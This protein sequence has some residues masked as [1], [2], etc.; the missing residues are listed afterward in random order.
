MYSNLSFSDLELRSAFY[1]TRNQISSGSISIVIPPDNFSQQTWIRRQMTNAGAIAY[2]NTLSVVVPTALRE[3]FR[4]FL[5]N[6]IAEGG[7]SVALGAVAG[8]LPCF[9]HAAGLC[10]DI[11]NNT[12]TRWTIVG[13]VLCFVLPMA[14]VTALIVLGSMSNPAVAAAYASANFIYTPLRDIVQHYF[15]LENNLDPDAYTNRL[16]S[17]IGSLAYVPNQFVVNE[18]MQ[19]GSDALETWTNPVVAN[20]IARPAVNFLGENVDEAVSLASRAYMTGTEVRV[21][22]RFSPPS[23]NSWRGVIDKILRVHA[24]RSS[25]F[26]TLFSSAFITNSLSA[27]SLVESGVVG[28]AAGVAYM[29]FMLSC[30]KRENDIEMGLPQKNSPAEYARMDTF[31]VINERNRRRTI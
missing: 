12:Y 29:P 19:R 7:A 16:S 13:S 26:S 28:G 22:T 9:L 21:N 17:L 8:Y 27:S 18:L 10:R 31:H 25:L 2:R 30:E 5:F 20:M 24:S 11:R 23:N 3:F 1:D 15:R 14:G 4:R 6:R